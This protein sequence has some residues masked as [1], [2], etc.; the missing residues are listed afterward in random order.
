[1][2]VSWQKYRVQVRILLESIPSA[3]N[4][5][6]KF[7]QYVLLGRWSHQQ[8]GLRFRHPLSLRRGPNGPPTPHRPWGV[9]TLLP[10][11]WRL[12]F[13][14][15]ILKPH[16]LI[17]IIYFF[18]NTVILEFRWCTVYSHRRA[19]PL[20]KSITALSQPA[21]AKP[22]AFLGRPTVWLNTATCLGKRTKNVT[23][24]GWRCSKA[25][26]VFSTGGL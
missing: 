20:P 10:E 1:M 13:D 24:S 7:T 22:K 16:H 8:D 21:V 2:H 25:H 26:T 9:T 11:N 18:V 17:N 14:S 23:S 12:L 5:T 19:V 6:K 3:C 4:S 15:E